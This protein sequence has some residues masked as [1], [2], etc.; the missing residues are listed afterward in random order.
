MSVVIG[1]KQ[2]GKVYLAA[3]T[4]VTY[5]DS[6]RYLRNL[7]AQKIWKVDSVDNCIMGGVG[8]LRNVSLIRYAPTSLFPE[9]DILKGN[10]NTGTLINF[11]APTI[12]STIIEYDNIMG[13][14][15]KD[16]TSSIFVIGYK[17]KLF[18]IWSDGEVEEYDN[19]IAIGSGADAA[20]ASLMHSE[21][22]DADVRLV[23]AL[24][25]AS[26][27]SLYVDGP[28][29]AIDTEDTICYDP[30]EPIQEMTEEEEAQEI[31]EVLDNMVNEILPQLGIT[32]EDIKKYIE[33]IEKE[34]S[35][36][37]SEAA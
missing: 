23:K 6:K 35:G 22:E 31:K 32:V 25:A 17:D 9:A 30:E 4:M 34:D 29:I 28:Y 24:E 15:S 10:I 20:L 13:T 21:G 19:Y 2:N 8:Y 37:N 26:N 7:D 27:I 18:S 1:L 16:E 3:D 5:G 14:K 33:T 11:T 12:A 36:N